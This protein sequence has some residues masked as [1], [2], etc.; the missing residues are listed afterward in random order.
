MKSQRLEAFS[1]GILAIIIT[2]MVLEF[3]VPDGSSFRELKFLLPKIISYLLSFIYVGIYWGNHH[4]IFQIIEKVNGKLLWANLNLMFWI[5]LMP[6]ATAWMGENSFKSNPVALYGFVLLMT[7]IA[8]R[9]L[10]KAS[11]KLEG[12]GSKISKALGA[13]KKENLSVLAYVAGIAISF[14][15][16]YASLAIFFLVALFWIVPDKRV[17]EVID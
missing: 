17:E 14:F 6:F 8:F 3:T 10:E 13:G 12:K 15:Y 5:S 4:H 9:I 11:I 16:A 7:S 2:I 1:D